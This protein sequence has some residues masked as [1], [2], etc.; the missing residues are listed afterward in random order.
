MKDGNG[1]GCGQV[2]LCGAGKAKKDKL[3]FAGN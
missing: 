3:N 1:S 2:S